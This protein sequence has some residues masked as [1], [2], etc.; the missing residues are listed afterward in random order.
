MA[1][2]DLDFATMDSLVLASMD[3]MDPDS[4]LFPP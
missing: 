4:A 1:S 2:L 3:S